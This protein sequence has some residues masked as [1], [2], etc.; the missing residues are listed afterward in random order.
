MDSFLI[1]LCLF[2]IHFCIHFLYTHTHTRTHSNI[3]YTNRIMAHSI[4]LFREGERKKLI[5][6]GSNSTTRAYCITGIKPRNPY[7][8]GWMD[9]LELYASFNSLKITRGSADGRQFYGVSPKNNDGC[10]EFSEADV[11]MLAAAVPNT[12][13]NDDDVSILQMSK[14]KCYA[15]AE[16]I[17][18]DHVE[19]G[20]LMFC[21]R[22]SS[23]VEKL[24]LKHMDITQILS[25]EPTTEESMLLEVNVEKRKRDAMLYLSKSMDQIQVKP[26][27]NNDNNNK[28]ER[29]YQATK[30]T[31]ADEMWNVFD[32]QKSVQV[33]TKKL[34]L[35]WDVNIEYNMFQDDKN[36]Q[37]N[38]W[39][40]DRR[41]RNEKNEAIQRMGKVFAEEERDARLEMAF[42]LFEDQPKHQRT[43]IDFKQKLVTQIEKP[44][45]HT[46]TGTISCFSCSVLF[47]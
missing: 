31:C 33:T 35:D 15:V 2:P 29:W 16:E 40:S 8:S 14:V 10:P 11:S 9:N 18:H 12:V 38:T 24:A 36:L 1:S 27:D 19:K 25:A 32:G 46:V 34:D 42:D 47:Q 21:P 7:S 23:D 44:S 43:F 13:A 17:I 39:R 41:R 28:L 20:V 22:A 4:K 3:A 30:M 45:N 6:R 5:S 37:A 26:K